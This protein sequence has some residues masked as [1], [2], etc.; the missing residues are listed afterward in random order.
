MDDAR[1]LV[2]VNLRKRDDGTM[3]AFKRPLEP[4]VV[5]L[6][7]DERQSYHQLRVKPEPAAVA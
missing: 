4:Y 1:W 3:E 7:A 5:P 2:H 6:D